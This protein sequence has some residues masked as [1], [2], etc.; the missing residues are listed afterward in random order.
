MNFAVHIGFADA[1]RDELRVLGAKIKNE[2]HST[3]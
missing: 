1:A 2:D 3:L